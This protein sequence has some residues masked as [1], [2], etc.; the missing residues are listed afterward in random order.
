[1][2][3]KSDRGIPGSGTL[4]VVAAVLAILAAG[5][6]VLWL[7]LAGRPVSGTP[8][9]LPQGLEA[10]AAYPNEPVPV[11]VYL[12]SDGTLVPASV[13]I[14]RQAD[15]QSQA[16]E[17]VSELLSD[18]QQAR[19]AALAGVKLRDLYLD[20][21]GTAYL[22]LTVV[23]KEGVRSSAWEEL[24][25]AYALVNTVMHNVEEVRQVRFLV[26]GREAQT[27]AGHIDFSRSFTKRMDLVKQ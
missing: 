4:L 9:A 19:G 11:T 7:K 10:P 2:S 8:G 23:P 13:R 14:K 6:F 26:E 25:A 20:G 1:M 21:S 3:E 18:G 27:L 15:A 12:P 22:D 24:L 17:V 16:R 5:G